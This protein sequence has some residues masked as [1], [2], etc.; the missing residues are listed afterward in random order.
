MTRRRRH[1]SS[2]KLSIRKHSKRFCSCVLMA[3]LIIRTTLQPSSGITKRYCCRRI[4]QAI[5]TIPFSTMPADVVSTSP[6]CVLSPF[7]ARASA[8]LVVQKKKKEENQNQLLFSLEEMVQE[9]PAALTKR[10][11]LN[12]EPGAPQDPV[13]H[14]FR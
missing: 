7:L 9:I 14:L 11:L 12:I 3:S 6:T 1:L 5:Y 2:S 13:C 4:P 8:S 10:K